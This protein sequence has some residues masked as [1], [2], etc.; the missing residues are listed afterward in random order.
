MAKPDVIIP[1]VTGETIQNGSMV[2][3]TFESG[4]N[5]QIRPPEVN[6]HMPSGLIEDRYADRFDDITYYFCC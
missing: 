5:T 3:L 4:Q 6:Q 1:A 2:V